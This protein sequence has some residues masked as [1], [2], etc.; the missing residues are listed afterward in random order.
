MAKSRIREPFSYDILF[1]GDIPGD[2]AL[3]PAKTTTMKDR[4]EGR[5]FVLGDSIDT[6]QIIPAVHLVYSMTEPEERRMYGRYACSGVPSA[7]SGLPEGGIPLTGQ[8]AWKSE[9]TILVA[10]SNFGCGSSR[11]HAPFALKEAGIEAVVATSYARIF[12]RNAVDGGFVVPFESE[13]R[14]IEQI[15]TGDRVI[16]DTAAGTLK[17]EPADEDFLLRPLGEVADILRA[18]NV[19]AY[20]RQAGLMP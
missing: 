20:A 14:L 18:G 1:P 17:H 16:I 12:Y 8:D 7:Q 15:R 4:I 19:F 11:E 2:G 10:G 13:E 9:F 5:A 3:L 6:D